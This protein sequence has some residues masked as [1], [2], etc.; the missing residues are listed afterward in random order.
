MSKEIEENHTLVA[1]AKKMATLK[2]L[3]EEAI[4]GEVGGALIAGNGKIFTGRNLHA[5]CGIG[6]CGEVS[7]IIAMLNEGESKIKKIVAISNDGKYMPPCGRCRELMFEINRENLNTQIILTDK[8][9]L[10][11]ELLPERWQDLWE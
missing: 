1:E 10:L 6:F 9:V 8:T 2:K 11:K 3:S 5:A 4:T 7:A